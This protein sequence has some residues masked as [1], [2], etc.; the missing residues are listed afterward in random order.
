[1]ISQ[2]CQDGFKVLP[3]DIAQQ[4]ALPWEKIELFELKRYHTIPQ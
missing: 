4:Q 1:M 3:A 2:F